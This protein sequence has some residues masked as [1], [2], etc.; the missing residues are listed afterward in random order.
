MIKE[1]LVVGIR[2][3][4]HRAVSNFLVTVNGIWT[5]ASTGRD[6]SCA[7]YHECTILL[8]MSFLLVESIEAKTAQLQRWW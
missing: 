2:D 3:V 5:W 1:E 8:K 4:N 6:S 7:E